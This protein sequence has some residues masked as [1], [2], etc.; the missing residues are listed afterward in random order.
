M[1][2]RT[3]QATL[4]FLVDLHAVLRRHDGAE[5][6]VPAGPGALLLRAF[7]DYIEGGLLGTLDVPRRCHACGTEIWRCPPGQAWVD[8]HHNPGDNHRHEPGS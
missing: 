7:G 8:R 1:D 4:A 3:T 5:V 6:S 2:E